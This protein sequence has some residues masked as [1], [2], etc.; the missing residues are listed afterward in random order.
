MNTTDEVVDYEYL[1][2]LEDCILQKQC[3]LDELM[4]E[5]IEEWDS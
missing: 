2:E 4:W 1:I 5:W 3:A